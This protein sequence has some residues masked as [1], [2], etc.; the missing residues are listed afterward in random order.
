MRHARRAFTE[1]YPQRDTLS[2]KDMHYLCYA[3]T[4]VI[5]API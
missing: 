4:H 3:L 5:H 1:L 2:Q